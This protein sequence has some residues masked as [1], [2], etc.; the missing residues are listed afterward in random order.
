MKPKFLPLAFPLSTLAQ[1]FR[2]SLSFSLSVLAHLE[3]AKKGPG[4]SKENLHNTEIQ[5]N[6]SL[7]SVEHWGWAL[8]AFQISQ[9]ASQ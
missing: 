3:T 6:V 1:T 8:L 4:N 7:F 5:G 2:K 9:F